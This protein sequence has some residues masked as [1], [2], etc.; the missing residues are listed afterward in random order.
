M[1]EGS[2]TAEPDRLWLLG[3]QIPPL[4]RPLASGDGFM[5]LQLVVQRVYGLPNDRSF[6]ISDLLNNVVRFAMRSVKSVR[7]VSAGFGDRSEEYHRIIANACI[8]FSW[9][10]SSVNRL[11]LDLDEAVWKRFAGYCSYCT[12]RPCRCPQTGM[13]ADMER[14]TSIGGYQQMFA[15]IYPPERRNLIE[16][17]VHMAEEVGEF[18]E[19]VHTYRTRHNIDDLD[20]IALEAADYVS[21]VFGVFNS[22]PKASL[23]ESLVSMFEHDCHVCTSAPCICGFS[24]VLEYSL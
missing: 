9:F 16:A 22:L 21:C 2:E 5:E 24:E 15:E 11:H 10:T 14:P 3:W 1:T 20:A 7:R 23:E 18:S 4:E 8:A 6:D 13:A 17:I 19:A 12:G